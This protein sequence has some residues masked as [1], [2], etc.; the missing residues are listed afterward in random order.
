MNCSASPCRQARSQSPV[1]TFAGSDDAAVCA[2]AGIISETTVPASSA[3]TAGR[4]RRPRLNFILIPPS[5]FDFLQNLARIQDA[6]RI[7]R[8]LDRA[9]EGHF[10]GAA[11]I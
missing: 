7:H 4:S 3:H 8:L 1:P 11:R 6:V 10:L 9:H 2:E 5:T